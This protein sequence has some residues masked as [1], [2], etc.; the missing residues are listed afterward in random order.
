MDGLD[1]NQGGSLYF[2]KSEVAANRSEVWACAQVKRN[3]YG[4]CVKYVFRS[5]RPA[6]HFTHEVRFSSE[7]SFTFR[8]S[9]TLSSKSL[10]CLSDKLGFF[11]AK[12]RTNGA[13]S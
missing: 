3:A 12:K 13:Q 4:L 5:A 8:V 7:G 2:F 10:I 9:G 11:V 6:G 1:K